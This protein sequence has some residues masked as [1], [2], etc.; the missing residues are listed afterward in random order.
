MCYLNRKKGAA[1]GTAGILNI[2][3]LCETDETLLRDT[4]QLCA[5]VCRTTN[6]QMPSKQP[7]WAER[8]KSYSSSSTSTSSR[9]NK[10][11]LMQW[12]HGAPGFV[13]MF[14]RAQ[15]LDEARLC[16]DA[17]FGSGL[18]CKGVGLC[19]GCAGN[20]MALLTHY[21]LTGM[22][23]CVSI[24]LNCIHDIVTKRLDRQQRYLGEKR[25]LALSIIFAEMMLRH[26]ILTSATLTS[27]DDPFSFFNGIGGKYVFVY[28]LKN[29]INCFCLV[30]TKYSKQ[31]ILFQ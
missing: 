4:I 15:L 26:T 21:R 22:C 2:L 12:C 17:T 10:P 23:E 28:I 7:S 31:S 19:H 1:H 13:G 30:L 16:V 18:L 27:G 3:S 5:D 9:K 11:E 25:S 29:E 6:G 8:D 14:A 24:S 20:G